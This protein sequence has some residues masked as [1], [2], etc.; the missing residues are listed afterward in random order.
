MHDNSVMED[1]VWKVRKLALMKNETLGD[2]NQ[3]RELEEYLNYL[4]MIQ[5]LIL[6]L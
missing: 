3:K 6:L 1:L 2:K 4:L 5:M